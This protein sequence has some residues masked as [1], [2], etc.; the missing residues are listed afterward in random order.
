MFLNDLKRQLRC[1]SCQIRIKADSCRI[2]DNINTIQ[3]PIQVSFTTPVEMEDS[4]V[5]FIRMITSSGEIRTSQVPI[6][7]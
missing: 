4:G 1:S 6:V 2:P 3:H 5:Y 7:R